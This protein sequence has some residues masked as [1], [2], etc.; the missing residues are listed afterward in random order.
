M[1]FPQST[2]NRFVAGAIDLGEVKAR[3]E[4]RAQAEA[5]AKATSGGETGPGVEL[6]ATLTMDNVEEE[7]IK[8]SAQVPVVVLIGTSRS[9]DSEQLQTD[10]RLLAHQAGGTFVFRYIDADATPQVAQMFGIAGLPTVVALAAG[11]PIANFE[12]GQPL[13]ALQQWVEAVVAAVAGQLPGLSAAST[14]SSGTTGSAEDSRFTSATEKLNAGDFS[15]AIEVY[16]S[17]LAQDPKNAEALAARDNARL[18]MR[19][20]QADRNTDPIAAADAEPHN[21][22]RVFAAADA[23]IAAG[24]AEAAFSRLVVALS[25]IPEEKLLIRDRLLELFALFDAADVRVLNAR[26]QMANALF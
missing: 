18:L 9:P 20:Q 13:A 22:E 10:F 5:Q 4:A 3:A 2:P 26:A 23:L 21:V 6:V 7:L 12:G 16:E 15:G 19:L 25:Q 17:I 8:R 1:T 14:E 11:Q 24:D